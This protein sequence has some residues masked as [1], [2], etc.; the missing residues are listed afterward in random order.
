MWLGF[1]LSATGALDSKLFP[2]NA[3]VDAQSGER[4]MTGHAYKGELGL[5]QVT[6]KSPPRPT[7]RCVRPEKEVS[8]S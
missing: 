5:K 2:G 3:G 8:Q 6:S 1:W 4:S 7:N